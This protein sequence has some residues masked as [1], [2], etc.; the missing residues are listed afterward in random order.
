VNAPA[1][2][3]ATILFVQDAHQL[4]PVI[5][6]HG[7][8]GGF[9]R[10]ATVVERV[11][12]EQPATLLVFGG[13]L[14]GGTLF[15]GQFR[16]EPQVE[17]FNRI[18]LDLAS[19]GQHDFDFG[20]AHTR[21][22][23]AAARFPWITTNL[24]ESTSGK[25][26]AGLP[27]FHRRTV[28]G[29]RI[30]FLGLTDDFHT[31]L[32]DGEVAARELVAAAGEALAELG[33][34]NE[35]VDAVIVL[36]QTDTA[37]AERLLRELAPISAALIEEQGEDRSVVTWIGARPIAAAAGNLGSVVRLDLRLA[38][39]LEIAVRALPVDRS[40][41]EE[42]G[43][44]RMTADYEARMNTA[45]SEPLATLT[46]ALPADGARS[47]ESALGSLVADAWRAACGAEVAVV[48]SGSLRADLP[49]GEVRLRDAASVLPFSNHVV[50]RQ[51]S[52]ADLLAALA[53]GASGVA[54][55]R[56]TL[57][58][59]SGM[60]Y[61]ISFA[62]GAAG[63]APRISAVEIGGAPIDPARRYRL[64]T[65]SYLA[66]GGDGFE[67]LAR[68]DGHEHGCRDDVGAL[69]DYLRAA[70]RDGPIAPPAAGR[71]AI[72]RGAS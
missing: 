48:N 40:I 58:H 54:T 17:A 41:P 62:T 36:A 24:L 18:K 14:A 66:R 12:A 39:A 28:G 3:A 69:A 31:T 11:R 33:R 42:P 59:V 23:V 65:S 38:P 63:G 50:A 43:L 19:F 32:R 55:R 4:A 46:A 56:G 15:G 68:P 8:R 49:A 34:A 21:K 45:L 44:A 57:L 26:F 1:A 7:E 70:G 27:R 10:L 67:Q 72:E 29:I 64:A 47:G 16:G 22:L 30:A 20:A 52:G 25:P 6:R 60:R 13:D 51:V 9:A 5:D 35:P 2:L 53:H 37:P 61:T 71:I